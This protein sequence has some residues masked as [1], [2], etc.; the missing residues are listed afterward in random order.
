MKKLNFLCYFSVF[1]NYSRGVSIGFCQRFGL[2]ENMF[3]GCV[4]IGFSLCIKMLICLE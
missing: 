4:E 2:A 3:A 1:L